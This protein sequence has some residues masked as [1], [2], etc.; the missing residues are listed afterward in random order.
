[1]A[2]STQ[3]VGSQGVWQQWQELTTGLHGRLLAADIFGLTTGL[4]LT[5]ITIT[6]GGN[7]HVE[8]QPSTEIM[9]L[10]KIDQ[11][12]P[13][14]SNMVTI[15]STGGVAYGLANADDNTKSLAVG[16]TLRSGKQWAA[17][18]NVGD[19]EAPGDY[20]AMVG[21]MGFDAGSTGY[22]RWRNNHVAT[23]LASTAR[24]ADT[25]SADQTLY[26][27]R[28]VRVHVQV[29]AS[30]GATITANIQVKDS[31]S[32]AYVNVLTSTAI[33][34]TGDFSLRVYPGIG[35]VANQAVSDILARTWRI[36]VTHASTNSVTYSAGAD[37]LL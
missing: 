21:L 11:T 24:T 17:G 36:N 20:H 25:A 7:L 37:M 6:S 31:V 35:A 22:N 13:G 8:L 5:Q 16:V 2:N 12:T 15:G 14:V 30:T 29:S 32:G 33:T 19:N 23:L 26:N 18:S 27:A 1:M 4:T 3:F 34:T 9:G 28:G 10:I